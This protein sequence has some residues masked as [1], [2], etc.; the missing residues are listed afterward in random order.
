MHGGKRGSC[1]KL[2]RNLYSLGDDK[3]G[4]MRRAGNSSERGIKFLSES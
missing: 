4:E 1:G 2:L 3:V